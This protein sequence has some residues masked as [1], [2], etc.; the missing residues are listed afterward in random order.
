MTP[1]STFRRAVTM[2]PATVLGLL[3]LAPAAASAQQEQP[4]RVAVIDVQRLLTD[5]TAGQAALQSLRS[6]NDAKEA[7]IAAK[8]DEIDDLRNRIDEG[9]LSLSEDKQAD[10]D[11]QLQESLIALRRLQDDANRELES[12]RLKA[13]EGIEND[14][15]PI[16][17]SLGQ[18]G[19]Y[20]LIF[21]KFQSGLLFAQDEV[22]ITDQILERFNTA[23]PA[24]DQ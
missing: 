10:L 19:G 24:A 6:L 14:V 3:V 7:E 17:Q 2:L 5:S 4:V 8:Q 18:A 1:G 23:A 12:Q 16:I 21:N 9:R 22:D 20:T 15:M 11:K 13:F